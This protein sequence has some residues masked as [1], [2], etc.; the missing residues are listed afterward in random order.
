MRTR[1]FKVTT[2]GPLWLARV[3]GWIARKIMPR[4]TSTDDYSTVSDQDR[5]RVQEDWEESIREDLAESD[6]FVLIY[7]KPG[8]PHVDANAGSV[9]KLPGDWTGDLVRQWLREHEELVA[10]GRVGY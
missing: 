9:E 6:R 3:R 8:W 4:V 10:S 7:G 1:W 5:T 2:G